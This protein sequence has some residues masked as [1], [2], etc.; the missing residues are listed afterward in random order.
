MKDYYGC[1]MHLSKKDNKFLSPI[2]KKLSEKYVYGD[3]FPPHISVSTYH[4]IEL[5]EAM[6][7]ATKCIKGTKK[8]E[9]EKDSIRYSDLWHKTLYLQLKNDPNLVKINNCL[10]KTFGKAQS[11]YLF[12]SHIS[13][14][15]KE[16]L[17]VKEKNY[18]AKML[19]VPR[20]YIVSSI[21]V[22]VAENKND[23]RDYGCWKVVF[24]KE[25]E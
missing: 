1:W 3:I 15:Y 21:A 5:E 4:R 10:N 16:G 20:K 24:E 7:S 6:L 22:V 18:L 13:L 25:L 8:F 9:V 2:I 12:N 23:P 17:A 19:K 14:L 11:P